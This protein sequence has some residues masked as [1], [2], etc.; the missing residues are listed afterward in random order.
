[1]LA[2]FDDIP[3]HALSPVIKEPKG[4]LRATVALLRGA[5]VPHRRF[6]IILRDAA[7]GLKHETEIGL[8]RGNALLGQRNEYPGGRHVVLAVEGRNALPE[9]LGFGK[10]T[11]RKQQHRNSGD[12]NRPDPTVRQK[13]APGHY[14]RLSIDVTAE[15]A[16]LIANPVRFVR[17]RSILIRHSGKNHLL[18][19]IKMRIRWFL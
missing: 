5:A 6:G 9:R 19:S 7:S 14:C 17:N 15:G 3:R 13:P 4:I 2:G 12:D 10:I 1:P 11:V 16:S 8:R 18:T